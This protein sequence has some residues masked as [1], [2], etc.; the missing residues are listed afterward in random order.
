MIYSF[1][2]RAMATE[3]G[4]WLVGDDVSRLQSV[5]FEAW[6]E[7]DRIELLLSR[8][9]AR[10][11]ISRVNRE[12][13]HRPVKVEVELFQILKSCQEWTQRT[14]G[15]FDVCIAETGPADWHL[16][17]DQRTVK[18]NNG[19]FDLGGYGKGYALDQ[20]KK[21]IDRYGVTSGMI[22]GGGSSVLAWGEKE[23]GK[24]WE[25]A[26]PDLHGNIAS[27][28]EIRNEGFSF[29]EN[30]VVKDEEAA[31]EIINPHLPEQKVQPAKVWVKSSNALE[32][33]V[34]TTALIAMGEEKANLFAEKHRIQIGWLS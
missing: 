19:L 17:E 4:L 3:F 5:A 9:D 27:T 32:A 25:I 21:L 12:A 15:Y 13:I 34:L 8:Y 30:S 6:Q 26:I 11:E 33:E 10:A 7:L 23:G 1:N 18:L 22:Q 14:A 28:I 2:H 24:L 31:K 29:S 20:L 16:D